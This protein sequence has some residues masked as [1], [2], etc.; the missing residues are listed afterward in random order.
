VFSAIGVE[1]IKI[2]IEFMNLRDL[3]NMLGVNHSMRC[4]IKKEFQPIAVLAMIPTTDVKPCFA[5]TYHY[6]R[7]FIPQQTHIDTLI[8]EINR[9]YPAHSP[10]EYVYTDYMWRPLSNLHVPVSV[11]PR[12]ILLLQFR[13]PDT[14]TASRIRE[15]RRSR[16]AWEISLV[17]RLEIRQARQSALAASLRVPAD[18]DAAGVTGSASAAGAAGAAGAGQAVST[19]AA[20]TGTGAGGGGGGGDVGIGGGGSG[21]GGDGGGHGNGDGTHVEI[22]EDGIEYIFID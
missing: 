21:D 10:D 15:N 17:R 19:G 13:N 8:G 22:G 6:V 9:D 16:Q 4:L 14:W 18:H 11:L 3:A 12:H 2:V 7:Y 1:C 20:G 5:V